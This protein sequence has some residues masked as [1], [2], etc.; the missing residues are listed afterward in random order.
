MWSVGSL[1]RLSAESG[2]WVERHAISK[3]HAVHCRIRSR[4]QLSL[5]CRPLYH[6]AVF[7]AVA[8]F[9]AITVCRQHM[10]CMKE[11]KRLGELAADKTYEVLGL[12]RLLLSPPVDNPRNIIDFGLF[13]AHHE[14]S[15]GVLEWLKVI[16][17]ACVLSKTA[18]RMQP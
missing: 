10:E 6:Q 9:A 8:L 13:Y 2:P 16:Y 17:T 5:V 7:A 14:V 4:W 11:L 1:L 12:Q 15:L 18:M 3:L